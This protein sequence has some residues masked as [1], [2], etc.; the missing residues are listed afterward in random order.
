MTNTSGTIVIDGSALQVGSIQSE[1]AVDF[2]GGDLRI[3]NASTFESDLTL[4]GGILT[5][6]VVEIARGGVLP[7]A[8]FTT[9]F[10]GLLVMA[11]AVS[12]SP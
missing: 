5:A 7:D 2:V 6:V 4:T 1:Q 9:R 12:T 3:F 8:L 10:F 11:V